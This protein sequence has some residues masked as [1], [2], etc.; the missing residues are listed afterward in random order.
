MNKITDFDKLVSIKTYKKCVDCGIT[1]YSD[2][3]LILNTTDSFA[4][5]VFSS[6]CKKLN[7]YHLIRL[8]YELNCNI[9]D[10]IPSK[11]DYEKDMGHKT[12]CNE[13]ELFL[14]YISKHNKEEE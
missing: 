2:I 4:K 8:S 12:D 14:M 11:N 1:K 10:F 13:K 7:L 3:A 5:S 6:H 9:N